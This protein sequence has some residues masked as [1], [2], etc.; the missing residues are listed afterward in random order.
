MGRRQCQIPCFE[1]VTLSR[2]FLRFSFADGSRLRSLLASFQLMALAAATS[3]LDRKRLVD[4]AATRDC[5]GVHG[6]RASSDFFASHKRFPMQGSM[7]ETAFYAPFARSALYARIL[8][9]RVIG[10]LG[11]HGHDCDAGC[12]LEAVPAALRHHGHHRGR[13]LQYLRPLLGDDGETGRAIDQM[14]QRW[15]DT[16]LA[17]NSPVA[18]QDFFALLPLSMRA[19]R[20]RAITPS[21]SVARPAARAILLTAR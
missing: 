9:S 18:R 6:N 8:W 5:L 10:R 19:V 15:L 7:R 21:E 20:E 14:N 1:T 17:S 11:D 4:S 3:E 16:N 12:G 13:H 2:S